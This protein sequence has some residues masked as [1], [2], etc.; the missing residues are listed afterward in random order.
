MLRFLAPS[1][2]VSRFLF[3]LISLGLVAALVG[4]SGSAVPETVTPDNTAAQNQ[5]NLIQIPTV[6]ASQ[7]FIRAHL[8]TTVLDVG[9]NRIAFLLETQKG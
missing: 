9:Q 4:C 6:D 2:G 3:G 7:E 1:V 5:P 8:A